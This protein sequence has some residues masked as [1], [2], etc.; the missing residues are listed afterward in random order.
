[1]ADRDF[2][3]TYDTV[4]Y[5]VA[6][7]TLAEAQD[8]EEKLGIVWGQLAPVMRAKHRL[9]LMAVFLRRDH[10]EDEVAKILD[11]VT[12]FETEK[13]WRVVELDLPDSYENGIPLAEGGPSTP[14]S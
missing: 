12:L 4:E 2:V 8:L 9:A 7:L 6:D 3:F 10:S 1:M 11:T 5:H 13:M 14:T